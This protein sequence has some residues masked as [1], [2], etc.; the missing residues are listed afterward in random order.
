MGIIKLVQ[1]TQYVI[2][3][4]FIHITFSIA[5]TLKRNKFRGEY[6]RFHGNH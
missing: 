5:E 2:I 3:E 1:Q 6:N 4:N